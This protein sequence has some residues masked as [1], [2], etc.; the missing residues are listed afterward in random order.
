MSDSGYKKKANMWYQKI[1]TTG[2]HEECVVHVPAQAEV[3]SNSNKKTIRVY[4]IGM[5]RF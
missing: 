2:S 1:N 4:Q 3:M 5:H